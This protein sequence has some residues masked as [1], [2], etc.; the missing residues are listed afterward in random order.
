MFIAF[1]GSPH[2]TARGELSIEATELPKVLSRCLHP[3]PESLL[4]SQ[5]RIKNKHVDLLLNSQSADTLR[6]RSRIIQ[7]IREFLL[8]RN[9]MEVETPVLADGAGGAIARA[10]KTSASE[11]PER[12]LS[13][14]IAPELWLK[15]LVVG[16]FDRIFEIGRCFRNEGKTHRQ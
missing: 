7:R 10:F 5:V 8:N 9:F 16:G 15:R 2:R 12:E 4:D 6:L 14:R 11:F 3:L 13:M 1:T